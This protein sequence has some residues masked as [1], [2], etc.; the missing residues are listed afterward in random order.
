MQVRP[1]RWNASNASR[2]LASFSA[3]L[4]IAIYAIPDDIF[5]AI[6]VV[7]YFAFY[8]DKNIAFYVGENF[9]FYV[10]KIMMIVVT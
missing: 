2:D 9:A 6:Y 5:I 1:S 4:A 10:M 3:G 8:V 7:T